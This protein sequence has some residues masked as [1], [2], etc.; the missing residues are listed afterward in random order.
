M[1][2]YWVSSTM[3]TGQVDVKDGVIVAAPAIWRR[4]KGQRV[5]NLV[6]WLMGVWGSGRDEVKLERMEG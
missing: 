5:E 2:K 6:V 1:I 4:F 3:G